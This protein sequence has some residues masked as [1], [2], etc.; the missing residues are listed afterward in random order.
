MAHNFF[1][2]IL[3]N[4]LRIPLNVL[5]MTRSL[6]YVAYNY[7]CRL[8]CIHVRYVNYDYEMIGGEEKVILYVLS[9]NKNWHI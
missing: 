2:K 7:A 4:I 1:F 6:D 8:C 3:I 5:W 9:D